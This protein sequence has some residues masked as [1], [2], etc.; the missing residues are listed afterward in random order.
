MC[1]CRI[2]VIF[3]DCRSPMLNALCFATIAFMHTCKHLGARRLALLQYSEP[4]LR[5]S[6]VTIDYTPSSAS[7]WA[8]LNFR[9]PQ[10]GGA[11]ACGDHLGPRPAIAMVS[12][13]TSTPRPPSAA[14]LTGDKV[15]VALP[16]F[17]YIYF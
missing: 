13:G 11:V 6:P 17:I 2:P 8:R 4:R 7:L 16:G 9:F 10:S 1:V 14:I 3:L 15:A 5:A 12:L